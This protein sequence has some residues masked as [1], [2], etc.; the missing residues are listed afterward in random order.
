MNINCLLGGIK[1]NSTDNFINIFPNPT[2]N[3]LFI[4]GKISVTE[5]NIFNTQG[6]QVFFKKDKM[7]ISKINFTLD[8]G[9]YD[10][11]LSNSVGQTH[12]KLVVNNSP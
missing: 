11:L 5:I 8:N 10:V 7:G 4:D 12:K 6:Q 9:L 3:V 2:N 1:V